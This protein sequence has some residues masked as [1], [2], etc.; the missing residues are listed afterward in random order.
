MRFAPNLNANLNAIQKPRVS[1]KASFD[2]QVEVRVAVV[3]QNLNA[4]QKPRVSLQ[5]PFGFHVEVRVGVLTQISNAL[6][7][8]Q[9]L[10]KPQHN[11][12]A[13]SIFLVGSC[14]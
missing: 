8:L 2:F 1:L 7:K 3:T 5:P 10:P 6:Q 13:M 9:V 14:M 11:G 12:K 4:L